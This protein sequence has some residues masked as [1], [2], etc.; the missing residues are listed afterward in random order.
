MSR[1][2]AQA[3][4]HRISLKKDFMGYSKKYDEFNLFDD[5]DVL[6]Y[7]ATIMRP[8][9][10]MATMVRNYKQLPEI[11]TA[12]KNPNYVPKEQPDV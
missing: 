4:T 8:S 1:T 7:E 11:F 10:D 2:L 12:K 3:Y 6:I 9:K 5:G